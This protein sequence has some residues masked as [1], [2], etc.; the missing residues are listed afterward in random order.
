MDILGGCG[1]PNPGSNP[2]PGINFTYINL[3]I[4]G[5]QDGL[6]RWVFKQKLD[7]VVGGESK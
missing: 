3:G 2:G 5:H 1:L 4:T 6:C 7:T